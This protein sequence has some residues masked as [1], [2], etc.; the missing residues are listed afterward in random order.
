MFYVLGVIWGIGQ[1][2][3]IANILGVLDYLC[4]V[5]QLSY[6]LGLELFAEGLG[7]LVGAPFCGK[8]FC[9][10]LLFAF[11]DLFKNF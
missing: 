1:G 4:T 11:K 3:C 7:A 5:D 8:I 2:A 6:L 9:F 10:T